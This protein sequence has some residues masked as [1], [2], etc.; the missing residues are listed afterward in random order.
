[1]D[2]A[3]ARRN[4]MSDFT[5]RGI[6]TMGRIIE[7]SGITNSPKRG[8]RWMPTGHRDA[9]SNWRAARGSGR[10]CWRAI[11]VRSPLSMSR[12]RSWRVIVPVSV[13]RLCVTTNAT[14]FGGC[15]MNDMTSC[16]SAFG[17]PMCH[18]LGLNSSGINSV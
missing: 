13:Q 5:G 4:M 9:Y 8:K 1:M 3:I 17:Y 2:F 18:R 6:T 11:Q 7:D 12:T 14:F 10:S 16:S 15:R